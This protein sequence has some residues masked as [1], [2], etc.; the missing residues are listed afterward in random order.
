MG[1][2]ASFLYS[3][4][5]LPVFLGATL[6]NLKTHFSNLKPDRKRKELLVKWKKTVFWKNHTVL[7]KLKIAPFFKHETSGVQLRILTHIHLCFSPNYIVRLFSPQNRSN[8]QSDFQKLNN[9]QLSLH[10]RKNRVWKLIPEKSK[11]SSTLPKLILSIRAP[12]KTLKCPAKIE[13]SELKKCLGDC[14]PTAT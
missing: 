7:E 8:I 6:W 13:Q 11:V 5:T 4:D 3:V 12:S 10:K 14:G 9:F 2:K 1:K